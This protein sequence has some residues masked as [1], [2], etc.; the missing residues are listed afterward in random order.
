MLPK[1][2]VAKKG[3][4]AARSGSTAKAKTVAAPFKIN[5]GKTAHGSGLT[6]KSK[7]YDRAPAVP[8]II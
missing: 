5:M 2:V 4:T 1:K 6:S 8:K 3:K 7:A